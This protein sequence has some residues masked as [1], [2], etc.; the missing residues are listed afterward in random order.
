MNVIL[1][2]LQLYCYLIDALL[3]EN[4]LLA[5]FFCRLKLLKLE[6]GFFMS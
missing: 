4:T 2:T 6:L 3:S 5:F 1:T